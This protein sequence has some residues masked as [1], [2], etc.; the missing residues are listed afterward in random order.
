VP[1]STRLATFTYLKALDFPMFQKSWFFAEKLLRRAQRWI[2]IGYSLP[3]A[4]YEF[5]Y[6]LKRVQLS[7]KK[8]PEII[9]ITKS[10][11]SGDDSTYTNYQ[12]FFG[13]IV[14]KSN[15]FADGVSSEAIRSLSGKKQSSGA[16]V[17][18]NKRKRRGARK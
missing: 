8:E 12:R 14:I 9:V 16:F 5:K 10:S 13:R 3:S 1:L 4:D 6:L 17:P 15:Y 11:S 2:F 7:R 18:K